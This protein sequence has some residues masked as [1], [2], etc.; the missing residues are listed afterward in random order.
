MKTISRR[1]K[2]ALVAG[3]SIV[4]L[5]GIIAYAV[6]L[7]PLGVGTISDSEFLGGPAT[8]TVRTISFAPGEASAWHYHPGPVFNVV[9]RGTVTV[10]D[11]C[12]EQKVFTPGQ[13]FEEGA[14]VHRVNNLG[15]E[16]TLAYQA[17]MIPAGSPTIVN[18]PNNERRCGPPRN[19]NECG[20]GGWVYFIQ[21]HTFNNQ[22]DCQQYVITG[23]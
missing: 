15:T 14:R 20:N 4:V 17:L 21:P 8:V 6:T 2:V 13:A 12:G 23:K 10:E 19:V 22:G 11:A 18:T 1:N 16:A 9:T 3:L 7:T 5:F